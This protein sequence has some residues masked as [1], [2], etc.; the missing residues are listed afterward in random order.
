LRPDPAVMH[1]RVPTC[2]P[3]PGLARMFSRLQKLKDTE[4]LP[5]NWKKE[6]DPETG[7]CVGCGRNAGSKGGGG[8]ALHQGR[9]YCMLA[10]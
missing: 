6:R 7:A 2:A 1:H 10:L 5:P 4:V 3:A 8:V 9:V